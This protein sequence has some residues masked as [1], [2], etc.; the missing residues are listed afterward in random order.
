MT[1]L[2]NEFATI[3]ADDTVGETFVLADSTEFQGI[4]LHETNNDDMIRGGRTT[5]TAL[6]SA[7]ACISIGDSVWRESDEPP[8]KY[9]VRDREPDTRNIT[10]AL[11][12]EKQDA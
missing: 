5:V 4:W 3:I 9:K 7:T 11:T 8:V 10:E 1:D 6:R 2:A 12:L